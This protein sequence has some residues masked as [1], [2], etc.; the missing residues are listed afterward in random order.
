[1]KKLF[2]LLLALFALTNCYAQHWNSENDINNYYN[3]EIN[4]KREEI[5]KF[6]QQ[7]RYAQGLP[8]KDA[9]GNSNKEK[10]DLLVEAGVMIQ[11]LKQEIANL[12]EERSKQTE[13][14]RQKKAA[15]E[16]QR[17]QEQIEQNKRQ[18]EAIRQKNLQAQKEQQAATQTKKRQ[19]EEEKKRK[20]E[21]E[22][23]AKNKAEEE[24]RRKAELER[25]KLDEERR[26]NDG[27]NSSLK[28][29]A[30]GYAKKQQTLNQMDDNMAYLKSIPGSEIDGLPR[31][32]GYVRETGPS[33]TPKRSKAGIL[34]NVKRGENED[35]KRAK[36]LKELEELKQQNAKRKEELDKLRQK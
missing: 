8:D 36:L 7:R 4:K 31:H 28:S 18:Q 24:A 13:A 10:L 9:Y 3:S 34:N 14:F 25:K 27:Y 23:R 22:L 15:E 20:A 32:S 1:M 19:L 17:K 33:T 2:F 11:V 5:S 6:E 26:Y 30:Q 29:S 21:E 35:A 16:A 12:E